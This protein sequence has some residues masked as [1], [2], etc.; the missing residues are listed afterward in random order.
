MNFNA[1][2][3]GARRPA[4]A[5]ACLL[6]GALLCGMLTGC[7]ASRPQDGTYTARYQYPSHG[8]VE[9]LTVTFRD[10]R[11]AEVEFDAYSETDPSAKK[12]SLTKEEYPMDPHPS[13]WMNDLER[14]IEKAGL[15]AD[16]IAGVA[17][18][19]SSSRHARELYDA[20][21]TAAR[22]G[23]TETVLVRNEEDAPDSGMTGNSDSMEN[24]GTNSGGMGNETV[25]GD[26]SGMENIAGSESGTIPGTNNG[27]DSGSMDSGIVSGN[28]GAADNSENPGQE[29]ASGG[30]GT[31][32]GEANSENTGMSGMMGN[33][34]SASSSG[35]AATSGNAGAADTANGSVAP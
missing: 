34:G 9:Y 33:A 8:Y 27:T 1:N 29:N 16:K 23:K 22:E 32:T 20:V 25:P 19:T 3:T 15:K 31:G 13:K 11:A 21:L 28:N 24:S 12:S 30:N 10:G 18:A 14:N 7:R 2:E 6:C 35:S 5:A 17:G 26:D 4:R